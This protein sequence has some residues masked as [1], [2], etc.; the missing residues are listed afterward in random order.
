MTSA[1]THKKRQRQGWNVGKGA[2]GDGT[3]R[4]YAKTEIKEQIK[5]P[6]TKHRRKV[7]KLTDKQR[8]TKRILYYRTRLEETNQ[9]LWHGMVRYYENAY[10]ETLSRY[11]K[12]YGKFTKS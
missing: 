6:V 12:K 8:L 10:T 5:E 9:A 11:E 2:K 3:E 1:N 4:I 7:K